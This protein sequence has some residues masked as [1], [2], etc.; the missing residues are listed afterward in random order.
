MSTGVVAERYAHAC[1]PHFSTVLSASCTLAREKMTLTTADL[2]KYLGKPSEYLLAEPPFNRWE[3]KKSV[4]T[5]L[6]EPV[7]DYVFPN[8]GMDFVCDVLRLIR[9]IFV[10][11]KNERRFHEELVDLPFRLNR[12]QVLDRQGIPSKSGERVVDSILGEYGAWDRFEND[13][14]ALH[15]QYDL[16]GSSIQQITLIRPDAV[17]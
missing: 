3:W 15:V 11:N 5:S 14:F 17:P 8:N 9:T 6:P 13:N 2:A 16:D 1:H 7:T 4:E 10:Y 12:Q